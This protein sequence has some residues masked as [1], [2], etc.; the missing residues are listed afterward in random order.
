MALGCREEGEIAEEAASARADQH[1]D[2]N[3]ILSRAAGRLLCL[4]MSIDSLNICT[5]CLLRVAAA[6]AFDLLNKVNQEIGTT[7]VIVTHDP[8]I[9]TSVGRAVAIKDGKTSTETIREVS[10]ERKLGGDS[11]DTEE[12][13]LIDSAGSV[14]I[15]REMLDD[16][17]IGRR[18]RVDMKDGRVTLESGE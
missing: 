2:S 7:I 3:R 16:L 13:L 10:L 14:Q 9:A 1:A 15:P 6:S 5:W 8:A 18:V 11:S 17:N 4:N 12:F